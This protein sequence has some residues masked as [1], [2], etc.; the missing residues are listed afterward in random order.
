VVPIWTYVKEIQENYFEP[1]LLVLQQHMQLTYNCNTEARS[2]DHCCHWGIKCREHLSVALVIGHESAC[3]VLYCHLWP[4][5]L[6]PII[7]HYLINGTIFEKQNIEHKM[8][9]AFLSSFLL[10]LFSFLEES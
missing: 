4:V 5:W 2:R 3:A 8:C 10:K 1:N 9:I 7:P 6:C